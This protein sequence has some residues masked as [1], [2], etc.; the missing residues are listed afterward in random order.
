MNAT[1]LLDQLREKVEA[2]EEENTHLSNQLEIGRRSFGKAFME[3][4]QRGVHRANR[5]KLTRRE[6]NDIRDAF[7]NG[8]SQADLARSYGVNPA[9]I[10]RT[11]RSVYHS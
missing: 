8:M 2:L 5:P 4:A 6:V 11:V 3:G 9:T 10:S 7:R 1:E